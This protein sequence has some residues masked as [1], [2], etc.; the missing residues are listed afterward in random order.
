MAHWA[1]IFLFL[2]KIV[3]II[4]LLLGVPINSDHDYNQYTARFKLMNSVKYGLVQT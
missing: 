2:S 3:F 1:E 4:I